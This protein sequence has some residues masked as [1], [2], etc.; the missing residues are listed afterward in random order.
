MLCTRICIIWNK[1]GEQKKKKKKLFCK[2][3]ICFC[4]KL[5]KNIL[6]GIGNEV[7]ESPAISALVKQ[8]TPWGGPILGP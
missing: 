7:I 1:D 4:L 8:V 5:G 3:G 6:F 2:I